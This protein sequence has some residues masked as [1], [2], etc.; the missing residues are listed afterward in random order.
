MVGVLAA[1]CLSGCMK[2]SIEPKNQR[3]QSAEISKEV[4]QTVSEPEVVILPEK[5]TEI[6]IELEAEEQGHTDFSETEAQTDEEY[7]VDAPIRLLF[8]G[9]VLLS[10]HVLNAY[11]S[12]GGIGGVLDFEYQ[13][14]IEEA[15]FFFVNEEFP[16]SNR[17]QQAPD[18]QYTFRL[19]PEK[20]SILKEMGVDAV[21]LA[22]NHALDF[23]TDALLD[24]CEVL[25]NAGILHTGAGASLNEAKRAVEVQLQNKRI[26]VIGATRVIPVANWATYG[27]TAGMLAAYDPTI[28]LKEVET[29]SETNDYVIVFIHWG[30]ERAERPEAYQRT[31]GKQLIDAGADLVIGAHPHVLQGVEYYKEKPIVYSLGNF[32][33][34]SS[35]PKTMLLEVQ[36]Q[37]DDAPVLMIYA[38]TSSGGYTKM[39]AE[40]EQASFYRYLESISYG[41]S[42][43]DGVVRPQP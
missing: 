38:G 30:I 7:A 20:V 32:V 9:D 19:P 42:F 36:L 31:L 16:F 33:F 4:V 12:A 1:A 26:A 18:K 39:L 43:E 11:Q 25:D 34:G 37:A 22:N 10:N 21:S 24:T 17:G 40:E 29:L 6:V 35:I 3:V 14:R 8:S 5:Q 27:E 15:D 41:V 2:H 13:K 23:G 28:L